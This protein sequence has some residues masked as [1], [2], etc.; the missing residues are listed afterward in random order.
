[1]SDE[2]ICVIGVSGFIGSHVAAE[3]LRRG[4]SVRGTLRNPEDKR[5]WLEAGLQPFATDDQT[6]SLH[7]AN[8]RDQASL[9]AAMEGCSGV[10]MSAGVEDQ[11]PDT[12][13]LMLAA[14]ANTLEAADAV[15]IDRVV[16]TSSTGSC[17]PPGEEPAVKREL[18][19]WSDPAQ[20]ISVEKYSPAAKTLMERLAMGLGEK[21][22]IR[23][24]I[25]N[26]SLILGPAFQPDTPDS[27]AFL[28]KILRGERMGQRAPDGSMS[29]IHVDDLAALHVSALEKDDAS[30]RYFGVKKSWH[31][32]DIL[33]ALDRVHPTYQAPDWPA[34]EERSEPTRYD[35]TRQDTLGVSVRGLD[36][37]LESAVDELMARA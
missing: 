32:Q 5:D 33:E 37:I 25:M 13:S 18:D 9:E 31:W 3:L 26:P 19:H 12:V 4:Y 24:C 11:E 6:L 17:N 35:L 14:A 8:L 15:G 27:L 1:M 21:L 2:T 36:A 16:F 10:V 29:I 34:G 30:G 20:Q 7:A 28:G 23:V 22:G